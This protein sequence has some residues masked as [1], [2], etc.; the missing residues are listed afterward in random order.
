MGA[1]FTCS[2]FLF[3]CDID[4]L[5]SQSLLQK[6]LALTRLPD[7]RLQLHQFNREMAENMTK[8]HPGMMLLARDAYWANHGCDEDFVGRTITL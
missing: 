2:E 7:T 1:F 5:I 3:V 6:V 8:F 4:A